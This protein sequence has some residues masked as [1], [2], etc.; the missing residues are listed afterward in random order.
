VKRIHTLSLVMLGVVFAASSVVAQ[1]APKK[2]YVKMR[3]VR[4]MDTQGWGQPVEV[5]H[6]LIPTDWKVE[7]GVNWTQGMS[8]C[9]FNIVQLHWRATSPDGL[10]GFEVFPT[11]SWQWSDDPGQVEAAQRIA[12][13]N[14]GCDAHPVVSPVQYIQQALLQ[15]YRSGAHVVT[16]EEMPGVAKAELALM[17]PN[18]EPLVQQHYMK[19]YRVE[20]GRVRLTYSIQGHEVEEWLAASI[21][22]TA[23]ATANTAAM[24]QGQIVN[25]SSSYQLN[26][27]DIYAVWAP[28]GK[29][30]QDA[31]MFAM[32]VA[33][34]RP[35][36]AYRAAMATFLN[37]MRNIQFKGQM[38][39]ARIWSD[40]Q[41]QVNAT[42]QAGVDHYTD[43][44]EQRA[45][46]FSQSIREVETWVD[47]ETH[48]RMELSN[49]YNSAWRNKQGEYVM[50]TT[51]GWDPNVEL[52]ETGWSEL[53]REKP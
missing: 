52:K 33:S 34:V 1:A 24:R 9:P 11:Y 42:R 22:G 20:A 35:N 36:A 46:A 39:R 27:W 38:D 18:Y 14:Q 30:E 19:G 48:E 21:T 47:P 4:I 8:R 2:N 15:K 49:A 41:A 26:A 3:L 25:S 16:T 40:A 10:T 44:Q 7:G 29:L 13:A 32:I 6:L 43:V 12:A 31:P 53:K 37:N 23:T 5:S 28:K 51:P 17:R 50:V 45:Q